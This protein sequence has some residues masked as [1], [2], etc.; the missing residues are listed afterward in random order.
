MKCEY[1]IATSFS[2]ISLKYFSLATVYFQILTLIPIFF[3]FL[4]KDGNLIQYIAYI[5][6]NNL[7]IHL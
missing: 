1:Q 7:D 4:W 5:Y 3:Y 6:M 2:L